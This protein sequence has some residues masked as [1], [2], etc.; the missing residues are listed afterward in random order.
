[1]DERELH[2]V[3]ANGIGHEPPV[4][5][6][7]GAVFAGARARVV[8][9]RMLTGAL[10]VAAVLGVAA[11]AVAL[12]GGG[13]TP[14]GAGPVAAPAA[15]SS[16]TTTPAPQTG[17]QNE[18]AQA[19]PG[20]DKG[21]GTA[22]PAP[23]PGP[24]KVLIDGRT[25]ADLL[26]QMLPAGLTTSHYSGQDS[27][28]PQ[29]AGVSV[30]GSMAVDAGQG[31]GHIGVNVD[32]N[33]W[34]PAASCTG[35]DCATLPDGSQVSVQRTIGEK[36][37]VAGAPQTIDWFVQR[38]FLDGHRVS[39]GAS[40][41]FDAP[42]QAHEKNWTLASTGHDPVV[43]I[44]QLKEIVRDSRWTLTVPAAEAAQAKHDL[45]GYTDNS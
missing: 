18:T 10:S 11:G 41:Y 35:V 1:M 4:V 12:G 22:L 32:Q 3:L 21:K 43:S 14:G 34:T 26:K 20:T 2:D 25:A 42:G 13:A 36:P 27:Y 45:P 5:G 39:V 28:L 8:K 30:H 40:N 23:D 29:Q 9:T 37:T 19:T 24:G 33:G 6:G 16:E 15:G 31:L 17:P 38:V 7:P 44:D